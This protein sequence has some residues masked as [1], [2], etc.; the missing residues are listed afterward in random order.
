[1]KKYYILSAAVL[2]LL[3]C[4][5]FDNKEEQGEREE[6]IVCVSKQ[7]NEI[8]YALGAQ[9]NLVAVDISSTYPE[10]IKKLP[11]VG[12]HRALS[13]EGLLAAKPT[14]ILHSGVKSMGPEHVVRQL[15]QLKIPMKEF[16]TQSKDIESTKALIREMGKYFKTEKRADSLCAILDADMKVALDSAKLYTDTPKVL[17]IHFGRANNVYLI[18]T[19]K[20]PAGK[21][22]QWA[23]GEMAMTDTTGMKQL[24]AEI[25]TKSN[26]DVIL[27]TDFGYD[28][29]G[30]LEK[31]KELPGV[32]STN[33][34]R[35]NRIY[36]IEEHDLVY[37][38]PRTGKTTLT[39]QRL[40]HQK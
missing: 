33:A 39:L 28:Q 35:N 26:P 9:Q 27:L 23:G 7:Y 18:I 20:G 6:R 21:M 22:I 24:S 25:V 10:A 29:L 14:L 37:M 36:R 40:I 12:Y 19:Q 3:S 16:T 30:S 15:E 1:M 4:G 8:I 5:R 2:A 13:L 17:I 38:G 34:V 11:T 32:G 31:I